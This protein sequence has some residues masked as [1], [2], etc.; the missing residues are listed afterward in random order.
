[1]FAS[2]SFDVTQL[3]G[4]HFDLSRDEKLDVYNLNL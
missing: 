1:M 2:W 4:M 3:V